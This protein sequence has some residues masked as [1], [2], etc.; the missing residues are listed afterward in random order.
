MERERVR[1]RNGEKLST[2]NIRVN[3]GQI[4]EPEKARRRLM[5][6]FNAGESIIKP[7]EAPRMSLGESIRLQLSKLE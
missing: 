1:D 2:E 3:T 6:R 5:G 7:P 4:L